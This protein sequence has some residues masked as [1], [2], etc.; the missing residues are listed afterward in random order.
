MCIVCFDKK[1]IPN[2]FLFAFFPLPLPHHLFPFQLHVFFKKC[3]LGLLRA[4]SMC[5]GVG[6]STGAW[7]ASQSPCPGEN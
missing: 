3:L 1:P 2:S 4:T 5:M 7:V 6:Q